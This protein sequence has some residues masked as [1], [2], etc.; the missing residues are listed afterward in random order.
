MRHFNCFRIKRML[1]HDVSTQPAELF[2]EKLEGPP[3]DRR[4]LRLIS[5]SRHH[6]R[7]IRTRRN[8]N[9]Y[10]IDSRHI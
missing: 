10:E 6:Q 9:L 1:G 2:E 7:P 5:R 8:W 3:Y 4:R